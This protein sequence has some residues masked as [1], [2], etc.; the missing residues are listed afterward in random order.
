M[1]CGWSGKQTEQ[2]ACVACTP[3]AV[4]RTTR[5]CGHT[6]RAICAWTKELC[7]QAHHTPPYAALSAIFNAYL[8]ASIFHLGFYNTHFSFSLEGFLRRNHFLSTSK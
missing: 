4:T 3:Y 5:C 2:H 7:G 8:N 1:S 6:N